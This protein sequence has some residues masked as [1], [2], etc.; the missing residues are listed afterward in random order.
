MGSVLVGQIASLQFELMR[1]M[2]AYDL[3]RN[4]EVQRAAISRTYKDDFKVIREAHGESLEG[5]RRANQDIAE[6]YATE[7]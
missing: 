5:V 2:R 3:H 1:V 7:E 4:G 6:V